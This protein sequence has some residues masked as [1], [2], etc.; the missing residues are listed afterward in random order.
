MLNLIRSIGPSR[1]LCVVE[2][3]MKKQIP[4]VKKLFKKN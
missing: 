4:H 1:V 2:Q 3:N